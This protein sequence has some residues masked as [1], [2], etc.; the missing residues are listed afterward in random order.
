MAYF[1]WIQPQSVTIITFY[2]IMIWFQQMTLQNPIQSIVKGLTALG[3]CDFTRKD[4][5]THKSALFSVLMKLRSTHCNFE[6]T[7]KRYDGYL[8]SGTAEKRKFKINTSTDCHVVEWTIQAVMQESA[9]DFKIEKS[10]VNANCKVPGGF[11][12]NTS[13]LY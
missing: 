13:M 9:T 7:L 4:E 2:L 6:S 11:F 3:P 12:L 1:S 8:V 5:D 10:K